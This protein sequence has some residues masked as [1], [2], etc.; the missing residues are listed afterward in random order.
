MIRVAIDDFTVDVPI[1]RRM[2]VDEF[3]AVADRLERLAGRA[4]PE[5]MPG[6]GYAPAAPTAW[7]AHPVAPSGHGAH[8]HDWHAPQH[9]PAPQSFAFPPEPDHVPARGHAH[10]DDELR[11]DHE[12]AQRLEFFMDRLARQLAKLEETHVRLERLERLMLEKR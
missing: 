4:H 6:Y 8:A 12:E 10:P 1:E 9:A 7:D 11:F 2:T 5:L 3:L